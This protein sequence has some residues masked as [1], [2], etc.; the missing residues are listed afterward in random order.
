MFNF[1]NTIAGLFFGLALAFSFNASAQGETIKEF[2]MLRS[3]EDAGYPYYSVSVEFPE[4][5]TTEYFLI[6][7]EDSKGISQET[8]GKAI[9]KYVNFEYTS[10]LEN[11]LVEMMQ[12]GKSIFG[13][14]TLEGF[15][16]DDFQKVTGVLSGASEISGGDMPDDIIV[17]TKEGQEV[18]FA[19][20]ITPEMVAVNGQVVD[21]YFAEVTMNYIVSLSISK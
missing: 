8:L 7:L 1:R 19:F 13:E 21:A 4:R 14:N 12:K 3:A 17:T 9:D 2:G 11:S 18:K 6:N 15:N 5:G 20:Y 10:T 16:P